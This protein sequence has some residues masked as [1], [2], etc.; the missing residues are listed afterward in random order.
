MAESKDSPT[1]TS[2][3]QQD[4]TPRARSMIR[5]GLAMVRKKYAKIEKEAEDLEEA[6]T[7]DSAKNAGDYV[8]SLYLEFAEAESPEAAKRDQNE[9]FG[10]EGPFRK[11]LYDRKGRP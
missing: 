3:T 4:L 2:V 6:G 11:D 7:R 8:Q 10:D 9:L 1:T 5:H